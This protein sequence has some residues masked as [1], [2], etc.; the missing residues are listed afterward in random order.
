MVW[1]AI[2]WN[3]NYCKLIWI[4]GHMN[5]DKYIEIIDS[6]FKENVQNNKKNVIFQQDKASIHT[7]KKV[8]SF[9]QTNNIKELDWFTKGC[10]ISPIENMWA[11][12]KNHVWKKKM[13]LEVNLMFG[14]NVW[15]IFSPKIAQ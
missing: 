7:S 2:N 10:D 8:K 12:M 9:L 6:Y 4:D 13:K 1:G 3:T 14:I 15:S 5:S 11:E